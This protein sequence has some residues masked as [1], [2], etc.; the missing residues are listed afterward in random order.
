MVR[1]T[2]LNF[3]LIASIPLC[4]Y[5]SAVGGNQEKEGKAL[6]KSADSIEAAGGKKDAAAEKV[7]N[8]KEKN[9]AGPE[10]A[11]KKEIAQD[12][13]KP[14]LKAERKKKENKKKQQ[15]KEESPATE[16][17]GVRETPDDLLLIDNENIKYNRIPGITVKTEDRSEDKLVKIPDEKIAGKTKEK[18]PKDGLFGMKTDTVAKVGLLIVIL[19]ILI[20]YKTRS[21]K[22]KRKV[23]RTVPK[24]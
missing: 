15:T 9:G 14:A 6:D 10:R 7:E 4:I 18:K 20:I 1:R 2:I 8:P 24:R 22:S 5:T 13:A 16:E 23:V 3:I 21:K 12:D 19:I 11:N 17:G